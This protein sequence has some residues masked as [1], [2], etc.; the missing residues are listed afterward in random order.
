MC[1]LPANSACKCA[2]FSGV[3]SAFRLGCGERSSREVFA[4]FVFDCFTRLK[5]FFEGT[6][7]YDTSCTSVSSL[8]IVNASSLCSG[9]VAPRASPGALS[10]FSASFLIA[11]K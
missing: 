8:E 6:L 5:S 1:N 4:S 3:N 2:F 7:M 11:G 10:C 9:G